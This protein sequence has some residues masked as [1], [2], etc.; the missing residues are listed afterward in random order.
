MVIDK[1]TKIQKQTL[2]N[3][4]KNHLQHQI[5]SFCDKLISWKFPLQETKMFIITSNYIN[6]TKRNTATYH[7]C[8]ASED[9]ITPLIAKI[10]NKKKHYL[11]SET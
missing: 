2:I 10:S 6:K 1:V 9:I 4:N 11:L 5:A 7:K 3:V 8:Q